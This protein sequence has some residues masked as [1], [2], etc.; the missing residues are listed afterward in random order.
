MYGLI[1][2]CCLVLCVLQ[3]AES[4]SFPDSERVNF[5]CNIAGSSFDSW[6]RTPYIP[7]GDANRINIQINFT[8]RTCDLYHEPEQ[9]QQCKEAF[10]LL[11]YEAESDFANAMRPTWDTQVYRHIDV[12]AAD[13][14]FV[15]PHDFVVNSET[16]SIPVTN[17]GVYFAFLDQGACVTL[18]AVR[19]YYIVCPEV[20]RAFAS[21][22]NTTTSIVLST[23][24]EAQ[25]RCVP[26]AVIEEQPK[27]HCGGNGDWQIMTG[28]CQC[29][30]GYQPLHP[31]ND[32]E[33]TGR[34]RSFVRSSS[35]TLAAVRQPRS[36][37]ML[38]FFKFLFRK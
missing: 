32:Q 12:I 1:K 23:V 35:T 37:L 16:R 17:N 36:Y 10:K 29:M 13:S 24:V 7:R 22:P 9:L 14:T 30:P 6:L 34:P 11:Y 18:M 28:G 20:T 3:W 2:R 33:C 25:G 26:H 8:M 5:V 27:Y 15:D 31:G 19:I 21:F 38:D 4:S